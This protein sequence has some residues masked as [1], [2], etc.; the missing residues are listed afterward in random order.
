MKKVSDSNIPEGIKIK[1]YV[2]RSRDGSGSSMGSGVH[3]K[4]EYL[5]EAVWMGPI[6]DGV[7]GQAKF[8]DGKN[9]GL[10]ISYEDIMTANPEYKFYEEQIRSV[11]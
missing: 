3:G 2:S 6:Y 11:Q 5:I 1:L 9:I 8:T 4:S 10:P 7:M